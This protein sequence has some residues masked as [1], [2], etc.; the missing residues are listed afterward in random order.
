MKKILIV[1]SLFLLTGCSSNSLRNINFKEFK[2]KI[3]S[4]ESFAVYISRTGCTHCENYEPTLKKVLKDNKIKIYKID[5]AKLQ[6][7][8]ETSVKN[9]VKLEGTP[10]LIYINKGSADT[11]NALIGETTYDNTVD[12]FKEIGMIGE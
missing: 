10:T 3:E 4:K 7:S 11:K 6:Q 5:L 1:I 9:K 2:N 8:E 12:F